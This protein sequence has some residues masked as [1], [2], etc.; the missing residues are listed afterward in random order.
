MSRSRLRIR[1]LRMTRKMTQTELSRR[2]GI[3]QAFLSQIECGKRHPGQKT[4]KK[5]EKALGADLK[6]IFINE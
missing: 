2:A 1:L 3:S 6:G 5:L 4:I